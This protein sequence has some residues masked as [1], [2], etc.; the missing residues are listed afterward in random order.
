MFENAA[1]L[2][3]IRPSKFVN[4]TMKMVTSFSKM[5]WYKRQRKDDN[6]D[7]FRNNCGIRIITTLHGLLVDGLL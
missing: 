5:D 3:N 6:Y 7:R 1:C 2:F 4:Q